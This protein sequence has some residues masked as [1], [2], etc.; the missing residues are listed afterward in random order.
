MPQTINFPASLDDDT[1][2]YVVANNLRTRL[3]SAIDDS[4]TTIPVVTTSGFPDVGFVT[5]LTGANILNSEAIA[6]SGIDATNFLNAERGSD[7]TVALEHFSTN[8]VDFT[9]VSRHHNNL[10][11][12][13]I[14]IEAYLGVSGSENFVP[15][16]DGNVILPG[17]LSVQ[18]TLTVSGGSTL[19]FST[20]TG[21]LSVCSD[22]DFKEGM[23]VSGTLTVGELPVSVT[24]AI[25]YIL[26]D[27][28]TNITSTSFVDIGVSVGALATGDNLFFYAASAGGSAAA[29]INLRSRFLGAT[30]GESQDNSE[31]NAGAW[32][33]THLAGFKM[34]TGDGV[35]TAK[36]QADLDSGASADISA[37][38]ILAIP[39]EDMGLVEDTDYWFVNGSDS[40]TSVTT[41]AGL[42]I[43]NTLVTSSLDAGSY[44]VMG[45]MET[46]HSNL[47]TIQY[48]YHMDGSSISTNFSRTSA[49]F[50]RMRSSPF[51]KLI[52]LTD[53][54]H[55]FTAKLQ[56]FFSNS[57]TARR[58]NL[59]IIRAA[60][61]DQIVGVNST[62][63]QATSSSSF[64]KVASSEITYTPRLPETIIVFANP[65]GFISVDS[66]EVISH[67]LVNETDT[68]DYMVETSAF[69]R[70]VANEHHGQL[71]FTKIDEVATSKTY[72]L[73]FL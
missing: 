18:E 6:Y 55:T 1:S 21:T 51:V 62:A 60:A 17:T 32:G 22:A 24:P 12:A 11:D 10:K 57:G 20:V 59:C 4:V 37:A 25:Q 58:A 23:S 53:G 61:F 42:T 52:S 64:A 8:N 15:F 67:K 41:A 14:N 47:A 36:L 49:D 72:S 66:G 28:D 29:Q 70:Q 34:I 5:I 71:L 35:N 2:L 43:I 48:S 19:A 46:G 50:T 9:I 56:A 31:A 73:S 65:D 68:M 27:S 40:T 54:V 26:D 3:T 39:L 16:V 7:D 63:N 38:S 45:S 13:I 69:R 44:L 30:V 33:G